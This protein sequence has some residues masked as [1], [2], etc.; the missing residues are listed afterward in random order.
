MRPLR[1]K[2]RCLGQF[3]GLLDV[4]TG[5]ARAIAEPP[6]APV[7]LWG[8]YAQDGRRLEKAVDWAVQMI[9]AK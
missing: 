9:G 1:G 2:P 4:A 7:S 6:G 3:E 8:M 5:E